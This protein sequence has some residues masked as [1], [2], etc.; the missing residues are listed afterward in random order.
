MQICVDACVTIIADALVPMCGPHC[1]GMWGVTLIEETC[2]AL[3]ELVG[4]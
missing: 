1:F 3:V 2:D 4:K